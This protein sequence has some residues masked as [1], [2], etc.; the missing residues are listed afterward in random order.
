MALTNLSQ[1]TT[2]GIATGTDLNIRNITG[3][4]ATFTGNVTVGGTLTYDDVT[5]IDSVG[6]ITARS[7]INVT[8]GDVGIARSIFHLGDTNTSIGF[9]SDDTIKLQ[10]D[11]SQ[12][13]YID[14]N[15]TRTRFHRPI[16]VGDYISH[17]T[18]D[19]LGVKF[20]NGGSG[21][22]NTHV[23][24]AAEDNGVNVNHRTFRVFRQGGIYERMRIHTDGNIGIHSTAPREK[25]DISAGRIILDQDYQFTWAN[26]TTNRARIYGDSGNNFIIEN[27]SS[28][29][30]RLR[31]TSGGTVGLCTASPASRLH[32]HAPGDDLSTIR[33]SG[34]AANQVEYDIRQGVVGVN[35]AGFSIRDV[36]NSATRLVISSGG[37]VGINEGNPAQQLHVHDDT[38]Y[39]GIL[40]NGNSAPRLTF[41]KS[42]ST[43]VEWGVGIDGT[44]GNN[45]AIAQAGNTPKFIIDANGKIGI[46][47]NTPDNT[48]SIKGLGSFDA[49]SNSFYFGSN[50]TG[51]GQNYIGSS[52]HAQR[53]FLNNASANGY[54]SYSNTGS[55][56]TAGDAITWQERLRIDSSGRLLLGTETEGQANADNL[57][58]ADNNNCGITIRSGSTSGGAIY[59]SDGTSGGAEYDGYI[60]YSQNSRF[61]RFGTATT[62][63][64]RITSTGVVNIGDVSP[65]ADGSGALNVYS[66]TSGAL[67]QFVHSAGNGGLRLGGT[68]PGS[69]AHLVFSNNYN[70]NSWTDEWTIRMD[71]SDDSLKFLSGGVTGTERFTIRSDGRIA[72]GTQTINTDSMLSIHR[73]SSDQSQIRFTNTTT[74]EGGNNGLIVGIDNNE[75]GR[76]FNMENHP[77]R[78][79]TNNTERLRIT[80]SGKVLINSTDDSNATM[81]VKTLTDNNHPIIKVRGT[82]ANGY[83][84]LGD[85]YLTDESQFTMGL[86]Y[87]G[88]SLVTGWGVRVSTSAND[89]YLSSQDTY[90][91]KHSAIKHDGNGWRFLSNSTSQTVTNGSAVSLT[92]RIRITPDGKFGINTTSPGSLLSVSGG[93]SDDSFV[94][95]NNE[96]VGLYLGA[97]GT[98]SSYPREATINGTRFDSGSSPFLRIG[99]QGGIK[100]CADLNNERL[101]IRS[102]GHVASGGS[103]VASSN[104]GDVTQFYNTKEGCGM[105]RSN[106]YSSCGAHIEVGADATDGWANLYLNRFWS[107]GE[108]ERMIDFRISNTVVGNITANTSGT[109]YNTTSD[110]RLK[111]DINPISDATDKLMNMNP[112]THKWKE[113][114]DGDTVHGFIAQEMQNIAPE[115]VHGEPDGEMMMGMD[116]GRITPIIVAALQDAIEE[117][118]TL[119]QRISELEN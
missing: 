102:D 63:R 60:E 107:S 99:G 25:L 116:Y 83:T 94:R 46:G 59:F 76:I 31:I 61:M 79:G 1:I 56:G 100:F 3:V 4:A 57:T 118:N 10:V 84:F 19:S 30:E 75:H 35:N 20:N 47:D 53:F 50:F 51:T 58:I 85:E 95:V 55:A 49:D 27:G 6:L 113:D 14:V 114:P 64:L 73:S 108:D 91:T 21:N 117:I 97:W 67:S 16:M 77:L 12:L 22:N 52:K 72:I 86:A 23:G 92:E 112:V 7:G 74:G 98:G 70:N 90:S 82:N 29:T 65:N 36:T 13:N 111:T 96:E 41:A 54:F 101:R 93:T 69:A 104:Y 110:I 89:T 15:S 103:L 105:Y 48:L 109:T 28:N 44:N 32:V 71:G 81:V 24:L 38:N 5:N 45:F 119:K 87:S 43:T 80:S 8:G 33:L 62:E 17:A 66:S 78:L 42:N 37:Y 9:P 26:G 68:G 39:Q 11:G 2:S 115:A 88:A 40:I 106:A 34:T 18:V